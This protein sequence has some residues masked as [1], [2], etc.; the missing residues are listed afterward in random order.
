MEEELLKDALLVDEADETLLTPLSEEL[1]LS[2]LSETA[3]SEVF[4]ELVRDEEGFDWIEVQPI[5]PTNAH[6][7]KTTEDFFMYFISSFD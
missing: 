5:N 6:R 3:V 7:L 1:A 4:E 2:A